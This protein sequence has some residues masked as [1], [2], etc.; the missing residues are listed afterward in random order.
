MKIRTLLFVLAVLLLR[1]RGLD[2]QTAPDRALLILAKDDVR[3]FPEADFGTASRPLIRIA[4]Y[5]HTRRG[6][7]N[8]KRGG[9]LR[10]ESQETEPRARDV[11]NGDSATK[12]CDR[13]H[14]GDIL[15][16]DRRC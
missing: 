8:R 6:K 13:Q 14:N 1:A 2:G 16:Q 12:T 4:R 11:D 15:H 9:Y 7:C 3:H 10:P 5:R